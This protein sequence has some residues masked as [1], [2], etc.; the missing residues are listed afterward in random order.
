ML[1]VDSLSP[2]QLGR[3]HRAIIL[4]F[5]FFAVAQT[6]MIV[7]L[8]LVKKLID[9]NVETLGQ[10]LF[11]GAIGAIIGLNL[12]GRYIAARGTRQPM[13]V[14]FTLV[15]LSGWFASWAVVS[16]ETVFFAIAMAAM[17]FGFGMV[18]VSINV[19]GAA[20]EQKLGRTI[21]PRLHAAYSIGTL[22]GASV[23]TA[24]AAINFAFDIQCYVLFSI[25]I[26]VPVLTF[27]SI[28]N[29]NGV[30]TRTTDAKTGKQ[31]VGKWL[32]FR[33]V[34]LGVGILAITLVEGSS[35]DWLALSMVEGY[36]ANDALAGIAFSV[37]LGAMTLTRYF[38]GSLSDRLGRG[39]ALQVLAAT[40]ILG[41]LLVIL[42]GNLYVAW[43]G[44]ALWGVG[45][46]LGFPLF[47]SAAGEG[48]NAA[49]KV[50]FVATC[51]YLAFLAGPPML[52]FIG[53]RVGLLNMFYML[54]VFLVIVIFFSPSAG[55]RKQLHEE[56]VPDLPT[57]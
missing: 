8:P 23:G 47:L 11:A 40:G 53:Q 31:T 49:R 27:R 18:D 33:V 30:A 22:I 57:L 16:H 19:D 28:P 48:E 55:G 56:I 35:N 46:S 3:W 15:T 45:V 38:G 14:G 24:A 39:R 42:S 34:A 6:S 20:I 1:S 4:C 29:D 9:V 7:R 37:L 50:S 54:V 10:I 2:V 21:M 36:K 52:G 41:I 43:F 12:A 26:L 5:S 25:N 51:G 44:A 32:D 13:M 17:F